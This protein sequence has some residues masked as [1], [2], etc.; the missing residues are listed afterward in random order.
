MF[1]VDRNYRCRT[2]VP[3]NE[4]LQLECLSVEKGKPT[5]RWGRKATG[6]RAWPKTAGLPRSCSGLPLVTPRPRANPECLSRL[7][8]AMLLRV[9]RS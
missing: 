2:S 5:E 9:L 7:W 3:T 4:T 8:L 6:L 1:T